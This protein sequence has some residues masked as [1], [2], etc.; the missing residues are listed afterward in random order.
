MREIFKKIAHRLNSFFL[1][2]EQ[3]PDIA[4]KRGVIEHYRALF[5]PPLFIETGTFLGDTV[6]YFKNKFESILTIELSEE[7]AEKARKRFKDQ[8][9]VMVVQG[10]SGRELAAL[11]TARRGKALF[12]LDGH[13]SSEFF[14]KDEFIRTAKGDKNTPVESELDIIFSSNVEPLVL[15]DDARLFNGKADYPSIDAV[16]K[17]VSRYQ[18]SYKVF[19]STDIIHIIPGTYV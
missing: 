7:L 6:E 2:K 18:P 12:W 9:N 17:R 5:Q 4:T 16:K 13:Y 8:S 11:L 1:K 3:V 14:V 10:D 15:I 19:V